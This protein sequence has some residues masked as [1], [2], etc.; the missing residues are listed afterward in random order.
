LP[1]REGGKTYP[2]ASIQRKTPRNSPVVPKIPWT[3]LSMVCE[4]WVSVPQR[5]AH[6]AE[7]L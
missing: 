1:N 7:K 4:A 6:G 3:M 2:N 5:R